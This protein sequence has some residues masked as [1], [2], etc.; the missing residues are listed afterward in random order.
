MFLQLSVQG[1]ADGCVKGVM[2][3][4]DGRNFQPPFTQSPSKRPR[5]PTSDDE[6]EH[7]SAQ[8][9]P[10]SMTLSDGK[11]DIG[12]NANYDDALAKEV[13]KHSQAN[14][15]HNVR[16]FLSFMGSAEAV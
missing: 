15:R 4:N 2:W 11:E 1:G 13:R 14:K 8:K 10:F 3:R 5:V 7:R 16:I 12:G 9:K 6:D